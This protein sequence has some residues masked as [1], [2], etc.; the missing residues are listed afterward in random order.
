MAEASPTGRIRTPF[1]YGWFLA[2]GGAV[3]ASFLL[4][5]NQ[6]ALGVFLVPMEDDLGWTR[7]VFFGA[8]SV[9]Y[10]LAGLLGPLIGP[11]GDSVRA[12]RFLLPLGVILLGGSLAAVRWVEHPALFFL[13]YGVVGAIG[14]ALLHLHVWEAIILKWFSRK[15]TR[16]L[17]IANIGEA[18]GPMVFPIA[19]TGLIA[20][21]GWR[22]AWLWYGVI[23]VAVL[24]P[25]A[26]LVR[27]RPEQLGQT[28]DGLPARA[29]ADE[30]AA[31]HTTRPD[32]SMDSISLRR[33]E[34]VRTRS[35]WLLALAFTIT[36]FSITGFQS[37]WIPHFR[38]IGFS[39]TL[40]ASAVSVYGVA[41]IVSRVLW[42]LLAA[43]FPLR[44]M[45]MSHATA[46][47]LGVVLLLTFVT[48]PV[49]LMVWAV[50]QGLV[51]GSFFQLHTL[52]VTE[53]FGRMHIGGVR[54]LMQLPS[55]LS[56]AAGAVA[57][58]AMRDWRGDYIAAFG[59]VA[60]LWAI[61]AALVAAASRPRPR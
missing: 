28:L 12:P 14:S 3:S 8:L 7:S 48:T 22:D 30:D 23:T 47:G 31:I 44:L 43:R 16:A 45:M 61:T 35:F 11:L 58:A 55:S 37:Q 17:V 25:I 53:H 59:V 9:R 52:I 32:S 38:D 34:A 6:F 33:S 42:G 15:R 4:G 24:M 40:A 51:L 50:Y 18:S 56:R 1:F 2:I 20:L 29:I 54:G 60:G 41:N 39:A 49:T 21:F 19:I 27:T 57:L 26:L 36:G 13:I 5:S 46:A 10:L